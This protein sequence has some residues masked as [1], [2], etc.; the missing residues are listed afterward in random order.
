MLIGH[1][2]VNITK[3][4]KGKISL[5]EGDNPEVLAVEFAKIYGISAEMTDTLADILKTYI[6]KFSLLSEK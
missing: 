4:K 3:T 2:E 1:I 6:K 5:R